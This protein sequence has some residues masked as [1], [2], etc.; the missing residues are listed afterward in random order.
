[1]NSIYEFFETKIL[2]SEKTGMAKENYSYVCKLCKKLGLKDK[3]GGEIKIKQEKGKIFIKL[4]LKIINIFK[5]GGNGNLHHHLRKE[6]HSKEYEM[7]NNKKRELDSPSSSVNKR[8]KLFN[9]FIENSPVASKNLAYHNSPK[10]KPNSS[11]QTERLQ[12]LVATIVK[13]MLPVGIVE[14]PAFID[15]IHYLDPSFS[16]PV[17]KTVKNTALPHLKTIVQNKIKSIFRTIPSVSTSMDAWTDAAARPFNG[18]I[19]Q[20]IDMNWNLHTVPIAFD[21]IEGSY[22]K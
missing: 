11:I 6:I 5:S 7:F 3:D 18:F 4:E 15:Y 21:Y 8:K 17:R 9:S 2:L 19:A 16:M 1:M 12:R 22:L 20:G 14:N 13:V 10:Y